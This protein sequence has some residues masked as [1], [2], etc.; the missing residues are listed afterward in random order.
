MTPETK[1]LIQQFAALLV[2]AGVP[3][4]SPYCLENWCEEDEITEK[5]AERK[6]VL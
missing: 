1:R 3:V 4:T 6:A 5:I 2:S